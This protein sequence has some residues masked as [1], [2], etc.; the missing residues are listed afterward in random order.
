MLNWFQHLPI[1]SI[2]RIRQ[3]TD[4]TTEPQ[5]K[6]N[7]TLSSYSVLLFLQNDFLFI[8]FNI[9]GKRTSVFKI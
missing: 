6:S 2:F 8:S 5:I 4:G 1:Y 9:I 7:T 3:P